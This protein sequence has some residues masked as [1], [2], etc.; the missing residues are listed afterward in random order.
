MTLLVKLANTLA[1][2]LH[3]LWIHPALSAQQP[4]PI[5]GS[6]R[7]RARRLALRHMTKVLCSF[8]L[9]PHAQLLETSGE[10]FRVYAERH[11]YALD[12]RTEVPV[13]GRTIPW[14]KIT[15]ILDQ[16]TRHDVVF[17]IDADAAIVDTSVDIAEV[18]G[19]RDLMGL[20]AHSTPEGSSVPNT[21]V[22]VLRAHRQTRRFLEDIWR[23]K[24]YLEH[25][26]EENAALMDL[27]GYD[28]GPPVEFRRATRVGRRTK[29]LPLEW[30]SIP[31][32]AAPR[33][34]IVHFPAAPFAERLEGLTV[35]A[36]ALRA[37]DS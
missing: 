19:R 29:L 27:L 28:V 25:K 6:D 5:L 32:D 21:G 34:R 23:S 8:G 15:F 16:L 12:L 13:S 36:A 2:K 33:P 17:W 4:C 14:D 22:W 35:A 7:S 30:N 11:G 24:K 3:R 18:L 10:T 26:W 9:G 31:I 37:S 1:Q 20:V